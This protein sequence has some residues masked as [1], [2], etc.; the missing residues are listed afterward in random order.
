[1]RDD[2]KL[3][4]VVKEILEKQTAH[5]KK[6]GEGHVVHP[7]IIFFILFYREYNEFE[8]YPQNQSRD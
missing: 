5:N 8:F 7:V 1:M 6:S 2:V 4:R 3:M